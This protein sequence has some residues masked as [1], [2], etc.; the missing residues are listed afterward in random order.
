[1]GAF[2]SQCQCSYSNADA[3]IDSHDVEFWA[4]LIA[5][6]STGVLCCAMLPRLINNTNLTIKALV[7]FGVA[8]FP[9]LL[10]SAN[11]ASADAECNEESVL[12]MLK[13]ENYFVGPCMHAMLLYGPRF[14]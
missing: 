14:Y 1:M 10:L 5:G 2:F 12:N 11:K 3:V 13:T 6:C 4:S 8:M 9:L 7:G